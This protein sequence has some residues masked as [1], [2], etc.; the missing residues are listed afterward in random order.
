MSPGAPSAPTTAGPA[1]ARAAVCRGWGHVTART[2]KLGN[3]VREYSVG[4]PRL[5]SAYTGT[6]MARSAP[7]TT[8]RRGWRQA[9]A[10]V[11]TVTGAKSA[12]CRVGLAVGQPRREET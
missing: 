6:G 4:R 5:L 1:M 11:L 2:A 9:V 12:A 7:H 10:T 8:G 3:A